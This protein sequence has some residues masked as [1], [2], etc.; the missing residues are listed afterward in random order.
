MASSSDP[1]SLSTFA[2]AVGLSPGTGGDLHSTGSLLGISDL[3]LVGYVNGTLPGGLTGSLAQVR[4]ETRNDDTTTVHRKTAVVTRL[5]ESLGYAPYLQIGSVFPLSAVMAKTRKLEPAPGVVVRADQGVD[6]HWLTE[7]FSPAFAEWLQRSPDDFGAELADGVLVVLRDGFL[8]DRSS[9]EALCSDAGRIAEEIRSEAL[10]EADSGGGSVAKSAPPDRRTQIAL[11][12]I[13]ELQLD[14]PPAH[15]EAA[16]GDA[17]HHAARSGAVI[18]RTI[19]GTI[20]IMLAVNIIGGGIYGLILNL[21]DPLKATL[22]Y[23]LILLVIIAPLRFRSITNNVATTA[24]EEA[25]YQGYERAHDLREVD[26]LRFAAEHTEA[27]LPGKPI[28]VMEGLFGGTQGYLMLTG[29]GRQRGDLIALVRGPRGPI[30]TTDLDVSAP[31]V[32]SAA[33]DGFVETL[34]LDLETQPTGV[35]AAGSA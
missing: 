23:Q 18:W 35:R 3:E 33:L 11:G 29:D 5:P 32:S 4:W 10:E 20:L 34:L 21:G 9:L 27:N 26:P 2:E 16:L 1:G 28:R 12:L 14:H 8:S 30:A 22:I 15:V 6:E 24:S 13:P 25:F 17:R 31:G 7:L 19:T